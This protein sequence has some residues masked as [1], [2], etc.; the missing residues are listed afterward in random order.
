MPFLVRVSWAIG[1]PSLGHGRFRLYSLAGTPQTPIAPCNPLPQ[2]SKY[3]STESVGSFVLRHVS[4][5]GRS[6]ANGA[7][8]N[9]STGQISPSAAQ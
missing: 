1:I 3:R 7:L 8:V 5:P 4:L 6:T 9:A 2:E